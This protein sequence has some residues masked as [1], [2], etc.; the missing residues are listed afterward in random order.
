MTFS[1]CLPIILSLEGAFT[2][3]PKDPG[4]ATNEGITL[5]TYSAW[6]GHTASITDLQ[7]IPAST[8][9]AIYQDNY[10][11]PAHCPSLPS[12]VDLCVFDMAVNEGITQAVKTLQLSVGATADGICGPMTLAAVAKVP[13]VQLIGRIGVRRLA[14]YQS[15]PNY[16]TFG[17][18][19]A[20]RAAI[21]TSDALG[22]V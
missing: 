21:I 22:M 17:T 5:A 12:G 13:P 8:V 20:M 11:N 15:L 6:L 2:N 7:T 19:W 1:A 14:F 4:G 10:Y 18:G 3:N 16:A 9:A